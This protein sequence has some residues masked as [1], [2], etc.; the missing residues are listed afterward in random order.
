MT[1]ALA[2]L[3]AALAL[4]VGVALALGGGSSSPSDVSLLRSAC[5]HPPTTDS[6]Y[7]YSYATV[8]SS[9]TI[10]GVA[11]CSSDGSVAFWQPYPSGHGDRVVVYN[12]GQSG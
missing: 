2:G 11:G 9:N 12:N 10:T 4:A 1:R 3:L 7:D 6:A 5:L 8:S